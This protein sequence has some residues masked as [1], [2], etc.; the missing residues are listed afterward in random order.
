MPVGKMSRLAFFIPDYAISRQIR[1][2]RKKL[3][4]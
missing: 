4:P 3:G 1:Y 2:N